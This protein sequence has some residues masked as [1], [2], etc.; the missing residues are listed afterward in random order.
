MTLSSFFF[1]FFNSEVTPWFIRAPVLRAFHYI[2]TDLF[3]RMPA[4]K[5]LTN[6]SKAEP[7]YNKYQETEKKQA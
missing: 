1:F 4:H 6:Y 5:L 2:S 3:L 7:E